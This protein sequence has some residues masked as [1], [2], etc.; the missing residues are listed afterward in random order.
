MRGSSAVIS[1]T[2]PGAIALEAAAEALAAKLIKG[3]MHP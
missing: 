1:A 3:I 2:P